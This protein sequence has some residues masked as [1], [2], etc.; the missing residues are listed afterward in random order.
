MSTTPQPPSRCLHP[1]CWALA[2]TLEKVDIDGWKTT[3][4]QRQM[5][6][7]RFCESEDEAVG[8]FLRECLMQN[9]GFKA[10]QV[11]A[12]RIDWPNAPAMPT[13]SDGRPLT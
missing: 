11:L 1:I 10:G 7:S 12:L 8:S 13:A 9:Q 6:G 2:V 5:L 4:T 3:T